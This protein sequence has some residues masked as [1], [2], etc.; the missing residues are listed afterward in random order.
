MPFCF[1][2]LRVTNA[3]AFGLQTSWNRAEDKSLAA[4][5]FSRLGLSEVKEIGLMP[6]KCTTGRICQSLKFWISH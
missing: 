4:G 2:L 3:G 1:N 5:K 6:F